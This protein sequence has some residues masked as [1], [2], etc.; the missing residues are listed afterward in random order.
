MA[1]P[2]IKICGIQNLQEAELCLRS[3][4]DSLG[5]LLELTHKA[6]DKITTDQAKAIIQK[7]PPDTN[8]GMVTHSLEWQTI[9]RVA[10][11]NFLVAAALCLNMLSANLI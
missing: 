1:I 3:G 8:T 10:R 6:E 9:V 2:K 4:A 7:L 11:P 5:F